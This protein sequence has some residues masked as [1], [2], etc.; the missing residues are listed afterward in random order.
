MATT[1][2]SELSAEL[3]SVFSPEDKKQKVSGIVRV[4]SSPCSKSYNYYNS[5][6]SPRRFPGTLTQSVVPRLGRASQGRAQGPHS[7]QDVL[8]SSTKNSS[9]ARNAQVPPKEGR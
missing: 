1:H 3:A 6:V 7:D 9:A 8:T 2:S 5:M 4:T